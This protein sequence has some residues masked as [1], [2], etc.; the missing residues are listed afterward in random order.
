MERGRVVLAVAAGAL[1]LSGCQ[2]KSGGENLVNG[3][4]KFGEA[5]AS[6]HT[7]ARANA[8]GVTGPNLD[9]AFAQARRDGLGE[10]TFAG[11]VHGQ[12]MHPN[13]NPQLAPKT[14][15]PAASMP[16]D[17]VSGDD[18]RDVAAYVAAA[19][20]QP[21]KDTGRLAAVGAQKAQGTAKEANGT[22]DIPV[23]QAG[24]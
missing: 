23:A 1:A 9:A 5:C 7:L 3:K 16:A 15:Q 22:L 12:I 24:L 20:A 6:C 10:S 17:L 11:I 21:G 2:L 14:G 18:A 13:R 8:T 19:A 4:Q